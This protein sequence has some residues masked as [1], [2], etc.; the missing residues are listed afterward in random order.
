MYRRQAV[1]PLA[2]RRPPPVPAPGPPPAPPDLIIHEGKV[3]KPA[4]QNLIAT[5]PVAPQKPTGKVATSVPRPAPPQAKAAVAASAP[6][7]EKSQFRLVHIG[8]CGGR[9][10]QRYFKLEAYHKKPPTLN[11][12][13]KYIIWVRNP[14]N[15]FV[16]GF[17]YHKDTM[18]IDCS[19][20]TFG[21]IN[22]DTCIAPVQIQAKVYHKWK[23][24]WALGFD[25]LL[26][27]FATANDLAEALSDSASDKRKSA[28]RLLLAMN[29]TGQFEDDELGKGI[30]YYLRNGDFVH[31]AG[32]QIVF[33]GRVEAMAEDMAQLARLLGQSVSS[34]PQRV[35]ENRMSSPE[36]R[37]L[38]EKAVANLI[39]FYEST[40]Y[41]ALRALVDRGL[42]TQET[43]ES[44]RS[45]VI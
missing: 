27:Q 3:E 26:N 12:K 32:D 8:R 1:R 22:S 28:L 6:V 16:S 33:V 13:I 4:I 39:D 23:H 15:R 36:A 20:L 21:A 2:P 10:I 31:E 42:L 30:G 14:L 18:K 45:Y 40:D 17:N 9:T 35:G 24:T 41:A 43:Y 29:D 11:P 25:A 5:K 19:N 38:S 44:Y 34:S 7:Q 37:A